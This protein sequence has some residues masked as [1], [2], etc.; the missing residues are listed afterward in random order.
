MLERVIKKK[1]PPQQSQ[2]PKGQEDHISN[3]EWGLVI[4]ALAACDGCQFFLDAILLGWLNP[5]V[6]IAVLFFFAL[7]IVLRDVHMDWK[8][9]LSLFTAFGIETF[10]I[11]TVD[12]LPLWSLDGVFIMVQHKLHK[13]IPNLPI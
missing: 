2:Q 9:W 11:Q 10:G 4:G 13:K 1:M 3:T 8:R 6:D 12:S 5:I 7:Y